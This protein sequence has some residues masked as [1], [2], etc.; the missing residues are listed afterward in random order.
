VSRPAGAGDDSR[1]ATYADSGVCG[2][3]SSDACSLRHS[4]GRVSVLIFSSDQSLLLLCF[5][6]LSGVRE[7][8]ITLPAYARF[9]DPV[10][11]R[12][13]PRIVSLT[14]PRPRFSHTRRRLRLVGPRISISGQFRRGS[15]RARQR[16]PP[17]VEAVLGT[18][19]SVFLYAS[20]DNRRQPS[21]CALRREHAGVNSITF[22]FCRTFSCWALSCGSARA[23]TVRLRRRTLDRVRSYCALE[24][25][26]LL[27]IGMRHSSQ[28]RGQFS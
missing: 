2:Q 24:R 25:N 15:F 13:A 18:H 14:P 5:L 22:G 4:S 7:A 3:A 6:A 20:Q 9:G 21:A 1:R 19:P 17:N 16:N 28:S 23:A 27:H 8:P 26:S 11:L 12:V 10:A